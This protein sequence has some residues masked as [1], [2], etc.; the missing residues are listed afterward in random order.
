MTRPHEVVRFHCSCID[1]LRSIG[2]VTSDTDR[3]TTN[4]GRPIPITPTGDQA[5]ASGFPLLSVEC[6]LCSFV[7]S[8]NAQSVGIV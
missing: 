3:R 8:L 6:T 4:R 2:I 1:G 5:A 7:T